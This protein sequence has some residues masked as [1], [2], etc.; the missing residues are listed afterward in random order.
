MDLYD[1]QRRGGGHA[2]RPSRGDRGSQSGTGATESA[3]QAAHRSAIR[4]RLDALAGAKPLLRVDDLAAGY[5]TMEIL[6]GVDL[7]VGQGQSLCLIGPNGAGKSTILHSIFGLTDIRRG[8]I[9][10][11]DRNVTRLGAN[12]KLRDAGVAYV[13]QESSLFPDMT[14]E[15]NLWL[16]GYLMGSRADAKDAAERIFEHYPGLARRR[17]DP[18]RV[19]SGGERRLL[20]I[21][22]ALVMRPRL[23][24]IDEPS[25]GLAPVFIDQ[26][27]DMLRELKRRDGLTIVMVEQNARKG[28]ED[29]DIGCVV[30]AGEIAMA[31]SGDELRDDPTVGRLFLGA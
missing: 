19:L 22:R 24:L 21:S 2:E 26:V 9:E 1:P 31:G 29:A 17:A 6:H 7:R 20:E 28:L 11:G 27:F 13:L 12:A 23:L 5:G 18:S 4:D 10:V 25:I 8:K 14:V 3:K 16:G 30:V 15:Q